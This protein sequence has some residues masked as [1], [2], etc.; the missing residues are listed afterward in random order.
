MCELKYLRIEHLNWKVDTVP[1]TLPFYGK[2]YYLLIDN[3]SSNTLYVS[4]DGGQTYKRIVAGES[5]PLKGYADKP[6]FLEKDSVK[7]KADASNTAFEILVM[8]EG[9]L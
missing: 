4:F 3:V 1:K 2:V 9:E 7:V 6:I 5:I 8:Y